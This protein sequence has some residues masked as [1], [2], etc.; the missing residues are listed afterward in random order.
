MRLGAL[1]GI[2]ASIAV[3]LVLLEVT[4]RVSAMI[5]RL[6]NPDSHNSEVPCDL[7]PSTIHY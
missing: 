4:A 1:V 3:L 7:S 6:L 2:I 5:A